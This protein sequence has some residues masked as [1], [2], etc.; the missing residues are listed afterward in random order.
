MRQHWRWWRRCP[1]WVAYAASAWALACAVVWLERGWLV[2]GLLLACAV[3][4]GGTTRRGL[5]R[6]LAPVLLAAVWMSAGAAAIGGFGLVMSLLELASTRRVTGPDGH[7][8]WTRLADQSVCALG[9]LLL[10]GTALSLRHRLRGTCP[11]CGGRH[12]LGGVVDVV[13]PAP[14]ASSRGVRRVAA[15]GIVCFVPYVAAK[16]AIAL[17]GTVAGL[18]ARDVGDYPGSAGW[19]QQRG[20]DVTAILAVLGIVLLVGLTSR[21]GSALPRPL[22]LVPGWLGAATLAPYG[23]GLLLAVPLL[24]T[25]V[26]EYDAPVSLWWF[27]LGGA[28]GPYG[29]ALAMAALS[30]QRRTRARCVVGRV[31]ESPRLASTQHASPPPITEELS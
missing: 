20:I 27:V 22:L 31:A 18:S 7:V 4:A 24:A 21:W 11:R 19:L 6:P 30:Y 8:A 2:A 1:D 17:G 26:I 16:T 9:A 10:V 15:V 3:L 29:L 5:R 14:S 12:P 23:M 28:F 25:G 13:R